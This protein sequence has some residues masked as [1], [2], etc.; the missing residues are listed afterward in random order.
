MSPARGPCVWHYLSVCVR[1]C[2]CVYV[3]CRWSKSCTCVI[4]VDCEF[5]VLLSVCRGFLLFP[6]LQAI[7]GTVLGASWF[8]TECQM[9]SLREVDDV[10]NGLVASA[11]ASLAIFSQS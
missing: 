1:A 2:C 7:F 8:M 4:E 5:H 10:W 9:Q 6:P 3:C 11:A